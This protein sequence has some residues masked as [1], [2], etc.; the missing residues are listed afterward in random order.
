M[1][2]VQIDYVVSGI[3]FIAKPYPRL[4]HVLIHKDKIEEGREIT[5]Q[6]LIGLMQTGKIVHLAFHHKKWERFY[7]GDRLIEAVV[8]N[9]ISK[10]LKD[11][12]PNGFNPI[13][14][15]DGGVCMIGSLAQT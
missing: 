9:D 1:K 8:F 11:P 3:W 2:S 15:V 14:F 12:K 7:I 6:E 5:V 4:T 13:S 10:Y